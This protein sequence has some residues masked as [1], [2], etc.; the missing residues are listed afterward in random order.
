MPDRLS[1]RALAQKTGFSLTTVSL[2]LRDLPKISA[3]TRTIIQNA[4]QAYGY[5]ANSKVSETMRDIRRLSSLRSYEKL[6]WLFA[7]YSADYN[8]HHDYLRT[9]FE[10]ARARAH[11][12]GWNIEAFSINDP[13]LPVSS[14]GRVLYHRGIHASVLAPFPKKVEKLDI[15]FSRLAAVALGHSVASPNL[16]RVGRASIESMEFAFR[17]LRECGYQRP[18][19]IQFQEEHLKTHRLPWAGFLIA[20]QDLPSRD[21]LPV[22]TTKS[23]DVIAPWVL[24]QAPDVIIGDRIEVL[25]ALKKAGFRIPEDLGFALQTRTPEDEKIAGLDPDYPMMAES[26]VDLAVQM[27][28]HGQYGIPEV[29]RFFLVMAKWC[30]GPTLR[31]FNLRMKDRKVDR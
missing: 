5:H 6:A 21:R 24:K 7:P 9:L 28:K 2:A 25:S 15:D 12:L 18:A 17:K 29:P 16:S 1:L 30:D 11:K 31:G 26:A 10:S 19:F 13:K 22:L 3:H 27:A 20:Q 14:I 4:A 8:P 23:L